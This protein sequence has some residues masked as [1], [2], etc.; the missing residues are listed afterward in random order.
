[1]LMFHILYSLSGRILSGS[2]GLDVFFSILYFNLD[3]RFVSVS[4][5][6]FRF[7]QKVI[8]GSRC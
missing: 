8:Q 6:H 7:F 4:K 1:M 3:F 5:Y 2:D